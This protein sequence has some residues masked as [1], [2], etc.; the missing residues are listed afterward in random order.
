MRAFLPIELKEL[1]TVDCMS[2]ADDVFEFKFAEDDTNSGSISGYGA[3][4]K[5]MDLGGD[6]IHPGAFKDSLADWK[7]RKALP[8]MLWQHDMRNPIGV[9]DDL[10]EDDK[11]LKVA[12]HLVMDVPQAKAAHALMKAKAVR[13]LSIGY[14]TRDADIDRKTGARHI[15]KLDLFEISPVT[16]PMQPEAGVTSVK[17]TELPT[18][19][20][21]EQAYR[22]GGL[23]QREAKIAVAITKKTF[24]RDAGRPDP[25]QR[26]AARDAIL[27]MRRLTEVARA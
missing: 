3:V 10:S 13:G 8:P 22:E 2:A 25:A 21:L 20:Q 6:I 27:S 14:R 19:R 17:G 4:F 16:I 23:S 18:D 24:L 1:E 9:W 15:K 12:G 11:G 7:K 26:E 5:L